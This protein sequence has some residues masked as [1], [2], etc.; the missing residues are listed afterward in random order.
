MAAKSNL[1]FFVALLIIL[2]AVLL[3]LRSG[4]ALNFSANFALATL[5]VLIFFMSFPELV[6]LIVIAA[7]L[8]NWQPMIGLE[9]GVFM[10]VPILFFAIRRFP[11]WQIWFSNIIFIVLGISLFYFIVDYS[12][13]AG[14]WAMFLKDVAISLGWGAAIFA[15]LSRYYQ[16]SFRP[17]PFRDKKHV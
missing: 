3:E 2:L 16:F 8:I 12:F 7:W 14:Q 11:P 10:F 13:F 15:A 17:P 6:A 9:I 1:N 5:I 4:W